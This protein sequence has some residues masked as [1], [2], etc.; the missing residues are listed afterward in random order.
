MNALFLA[1]SVS[2][3][4]HAGDVG[5]GRSAA[6]QMKY[7]PFDPNGT[8]CF[9]PS[10]GIATLT[11]YPG[12]NSWRT[13]TPGFD[14]NFESDPPHDYYTLQ[15]GASIRLVAYEDMEPALRVM[16]QT[17]TIRYAGDYISLGSYV[18]HRHPVFI[19]DAN[20]PAYDPIRTMWWGTFTF[21]DAG[22]T[23]YAESDPFAIRLCVLDPNSFVVGDVSED[24]SV[25]FGDINPFVGVIVTAQSDPAAL[26]V[27]QRCE[28]DINLDGY[29]DFGDINPFV[30][31]LS[32]GGREALISPQ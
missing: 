11:F 28:G 18:L 25:D 7:K 15:A 23:Q 6:D 9:D 16:Y 17:Q 32:G 1:N 21:H 14:A 22:S 2:L 19:V 31:M 10:D 5:V 20:D 27:R 8:P 3:A 29:V 24:G 13:D 12:S 26:T 4:Q 30:M